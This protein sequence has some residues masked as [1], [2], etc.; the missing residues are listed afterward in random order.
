M[1][2]L[3]A[4]VV[5][6]VA[7][8]ILPTLGLAAPDR[9][10][11]KLAYDPNINRVLVVYES[12]TDI[13]GQFRNTDGTQLNLESAISSGAG[14]QQQVAVVFDTT[15]RRFLVVWR[16]GRNTLT[17]GE[18]IYG[19]VLSADGFPSGGNFPISNATGDQVAP[20][21]A[22]DAINQ[23]FLVTWE[24][25]RNAGTTGRDIYGQFLNANGSL[26]G[27]NFDISPAAG[28]QVGPS[29]AFDTIS[30][31][32]LVVWQD[33][34]NAGTGED[35]YGQLINADGSPSEGNFIISN[36]AGNQVAPFVAFDT[37]NQKFL[38]AWEDS[39]NAGTG[40]DIYGQIINANGSLFGTVSDVNFAIS[41]AVNDQIAPFAACDIVNQRFLV[42]WRD[43]RNAG[44]G[45]DIY[46][47][48]VNADGSLSEDNFD[49]S[50]AAGN[51][52][53]PSATFNSN[54]AN[55]L[56]AFQTEET[57][58][59][60][61]GFV[62]IGDP[63]RETYNTVTLIQPNGREII[64]SGS[65]YPIHWGAPEEAISFE[66]E[67]SSGGSW[68]LIAEGVTGTGYLWQVPDPKGDKEETKVR[69]TGYDLFYKKVGRDRS[70]DQFDIKVVRITSPV[71]D[72]DLTS[73]DPTLFPITWDTYVTDRPVAQVE[74]YFSKSGGTSG[75]RIGLI[76]DTDPG[77]FL[78]K[79]PI[80]EQPKNRCRIK[81]VL[82][83][84]AGRKLGTDITPHFTINPLPTP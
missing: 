48:L 78:W 64:P 14:T 16:D 82:K 26:S 59:P 18:D 47:Q 84:A 50:T 30:Q 58:S 39:R 54:C 41:E 32:F 70:K 27:A 73:D 3:S 34:R 65:T 83:D 1:N 22:F 4:L 36:A 8:L 67:Y 38:V 49:I 76:K 55:Y 66:I 29:V 23:R 46:G 12:A 81:V 77:L 17:T 43:G 44:T 72:E 24:D 33:G 79:I 35:I 42:A 6:V 15:N 71:G 45:E 9:S 60:E 21:V 51:Q 10:R 57:G 56:V 53:A 11:P 31:R 63:C 37:I 5:G 61:L 75:K 68:K 69:V 20:S 62:P 2:R 74:I 52:D 28:D 80:V 25:S 19:Q 40:K 13:Y 7:V